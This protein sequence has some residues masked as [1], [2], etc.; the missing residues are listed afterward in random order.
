MDKFVTSLY[1]YKLTLCQRSTDSRD[2]AGGK[3]ITAPC[4]SIS[5]YI[6]NYKNMKTTKQIFSFGH[7]FS[8][9]LKHNFRLNH[10]LTIN[11]TKYFIFS[12]SQRGAL[13]YYN[14]KNIECRL[15][16]KDYKA[17]NPTS[18]GTDELLGASVSN[19]KFWGL[20]VLC[21]INIRHSM[22]LGHTQGSQHKNIIKIKLLRMRL[23]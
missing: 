6:T 5:K 17:K 11:T 18:K 23:F 13:S 1:S 20:A 7:K 19:L 12:K 3:K 9:K 21:S 4:K 10:S 2:R 14:Y 8:M 15:V 16:R 22:S